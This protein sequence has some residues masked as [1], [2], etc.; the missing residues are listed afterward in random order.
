MEFDMDDF[1]SDWLDYLSDVHED[2]FSW[3]DLELSEVWIP[4]DW[5]L[6]LCEPSDEELEQMNQAAE[7][8]LWDME[9]E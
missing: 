1:N 5:H 8:F 2:L 6:D 4:E 3:I 7:E 9:N